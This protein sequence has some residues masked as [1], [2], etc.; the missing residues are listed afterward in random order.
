VLQRRDAGAVRDVHV[1]AGLHQRFQRIGM[2]L[3]AIAKDDGFHQRGPAQIVDVIERRARRDQP[4]YDLGVTEMGGRDQGGAVIDRGD[5]ARI[6]AAFQRDRQALRIVGDGCDGD[7]V[8]A[9]EFQLIGVGLQAQ[10]GPRGIVLFLEDRNMQRGALLRVGGVDR[11]ARTYAAFNRRD[12][13]ARGRLVQAGI[14][15]DFAR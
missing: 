3:A 7:D 9:A 8:V 15:R 11:I 13:A 10:Q 4:A 1:R 5:G 12:I 2:S 14:A 6:A